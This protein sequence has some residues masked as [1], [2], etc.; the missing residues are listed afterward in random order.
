M[1]NPTWLE[2]AG[3]EC[4]VAKGARFYRK[5]RNGDVLGPLKAWHG[6]MRPVVW[7]HRNDPRDIIAYRVIG[8][9]A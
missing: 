4:P 7:E 1:T 5:H 3:G 6:N 9:D 8:D 2:W